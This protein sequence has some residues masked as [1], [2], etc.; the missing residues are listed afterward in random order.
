MESRFKFKKKFQLTSF[1]TFSKF[2]NLK[3]AKF[4]PLISLKFYPAAQFCVLE[5]LRF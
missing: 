4:H 3:A 5:I 1:T 2:Q